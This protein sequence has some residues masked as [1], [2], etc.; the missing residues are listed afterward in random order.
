[1]TSVIN[2]SDLDGS[3]GFV[4][5]G[6]DANDA[7]GLISS[8]AGD[9][10]GDGIDDVIIG[11]RYADPN[12]I[13]RAG[14]SYVVFG[15]SS[16]FGAS[17]ELSSLDGSNGFTMNGIDADD[18]SGAFVSD[19]GDVNGDGI[20]DILIGAPFG[21][22]NGFG[23]G[24]SYVVFGTNAGFG[25]SLELSSLDGSNGFTINGIDADD[26]AGSNVSSVGDVNGDG[27]DDILIAARRADPNGNSE[28]GESYVV[29]GTN[30]GFGASLELSSLDG[31]NGFTIN[32]IDADDQSG[33]SLSDAGDVNGDGFDDILIG[34]PFADPNGNNSGES[35]VV[36]G[37]SSGFGAS[38]DLSSLDGSN[39]F[40]L[41]GLDADDLLGRSLSSAGDIN[42]DG[43]DDIIVAAPGGDSNGNNSGE[44][45]VVFGS[46][47]GFGASF[48]LSTLDGNNGF[49]INGIDADD[50]AGEFVSS[51]GDVNGDGIDD[52]IVG[53]R[54]ADP[55]GIDRAGES[56]VV[57]G[58]GS[59][60]GASLELS[61][62]DGSNGFTINGIDADDLSGFSVSGAGDLNDDGFDD[63]LIGAR[64]ADPNGNSDA[65]E[66]YVVFGFSSATNTAPDAVD[67]AVTTDEDTAVTGD[68]LA[69]DSDADSDP[70]TV[71]EVNGEAADVGSQVT[72]P[73]GAL[74]T[75]NG[76]GT[77]DYDP[78]GAFESL[79]SGDTDT[80]S[81]T[82]TL[83]DGTDTDTA[84]V[85][86]TIDG[87]DDVPTPGD[88]VLTGTSGNDLILALPGNDLVNAGDGDDTVGGGDGDDTIDGGA[89]NDVIRGWKG[90]DLIN[91]GA[92]ADN[93]Q[94]GPNPDTLN[95]GDDDD[96]LDGGTGA[97]ILN[98]D[99]GDDFI[100]GRN[101]NDLLTGGLGADDLR[102]GNGQ[103]TLD[104]GD[105][106]DALHGGR[107]D[108]SLTG[109]V[110]SDF[111]DGE[112]GNDILIGVDSSVAAPGSGE[113]D[114]LR[115]GGGADTFILG[116][117][118]TAYYL[119]GGDADYARIRTFNPAEDTI[120]LSGSE[121]D[122]TLNIIGQDTEILQGGD[123][124]AFLINDR[125]G[126]FSSGFSFV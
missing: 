126:D 58:S 122:Y 106:D 82:Y 48:D 50:N 20:D 38:L 33:F 79:G 66:S 99:A 101:G 78:N 35:Y 12:G 84:T 21:N 26:R 118:T 85:T 51:A 104:G 91:G 98:G 102:G 75:L 9:V 13:N 88:D 109:G 39:G 72:L 96:S 108:D 70:L 55:N 119:G 23:S 97:D 44:S 7:S 2:L 30:A 5:N 57:F 37:S 76:D 34:A 6:I 41:E 114:N 17:L 100:A 67:D 1:M 60:F 90:R 94:G 86:V 18:L 15:S 113:L 14:E 47:S 64:F 22:P 40:V 107:N 10:N 112:A 69:N 117:A 43:F 8:H 24:E 116:D 36:F 59:G 74:L 49:T 61:S 32:G 71:T 56:Y 31:S 73:S 16:G 103:D 77:F 29:F 68:V 25:A 62:L 81:F 124:V 110:G 42:N 80:D 11:A 105:D 115:G 120:Q 111:L 123:R 125:I 27:I 45:Y 53:A 65:G 54:Q 93:L 46:S 121:A 63:I 52:L 3:N 95:G 89:G 83:S 87:A 92:G 4:I 19:A 28:A